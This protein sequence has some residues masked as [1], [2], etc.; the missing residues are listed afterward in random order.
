[1]NDRLRAPHYVPLLTAFL[2][3]GCTP[4][5]DAVRTASDEQAPAT[6]DT[7][8]I[9][10]LDATHADWLTHGGTYAEQRYSALDAVNVDTIAR[11]GLAWYVDLDTSRGQE[12]TPL[13]V[14]GT[15]YATTA[16]SK[17]YAVDAASGNV[18][19]TYD[20]KVPG[21]VGRSAC[22]DVVNRGAAYYEGKVFVGTLDGRLIALDAKSGALRWSTQTLDTS[23]PYTITGA[24]RA[25]KGKVFIGNGGAEYGVRGY[26]SAYDAN[27]GELAWRFYTVPGDPDAMPEGAAREPGRA[28]RRVARRRAAGARHRDHPPRSAARRAE[29]SHRRAT[30]SGVLLRHRRRDHQRA[31]LRRRRC[32]A[33][34]DQSPVPPDHL[35]G[36]EPGGRRGRLT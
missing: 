7:A 3:A 27:T 24:P 1:M 33:G 36:H 9:A 20:P 21:A 19:W 4:E 32:R 8:R 10:A 2:C 18:L 5:T 35:L 12:G 14:D 17:V 31:G 28:L 34:R 11:L 16:W 30:R 26:V 6:V 13:V 22:C 15:M 25:A 29:P 23:K